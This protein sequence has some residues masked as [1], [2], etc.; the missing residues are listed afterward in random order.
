MRLSHATKLDTIG[1]AFN[2]M[3]LDLVI[4]ALER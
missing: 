2:A 1:V 3:N 4:G